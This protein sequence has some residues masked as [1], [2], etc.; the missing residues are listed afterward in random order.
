VG[1]LVSTVGVTLG[2]LGPM[3][4]MPYPAASMVFVHGV[5]TPPP[6]TVPSCCVIVLEQSVIFSKPKDTQTLRQWLRHRQVRH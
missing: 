2:S 6:V 3:L 4:V 5:C 1:A